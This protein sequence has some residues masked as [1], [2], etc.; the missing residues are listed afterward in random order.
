[1]VLVTALDRQG[2]RLPEM[3][4]GWPAAAL[5]Q[6][7]NAQASQ[8]LGLANRLPISRPSLRDRRKSSLACR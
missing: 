4:D 6:L 8:R 3:A 7:G 5:P 2:Q 1:L